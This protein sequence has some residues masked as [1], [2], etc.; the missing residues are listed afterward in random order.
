ME[1]SAHGSAP[2]PPPA[3]GELLNSSLTTHTAK[4]EWKASLWPARATLSRLRMCGAL[5]WVALSLLASPA[6]AA[7]QGVCNRTPQVR[8]KLAEAAGVEHCARVSSGHLAGVRR[9]DL[10]SGFLF[11]L[12]KDDLRGLTG[13]ETLN[14]SGNR[15]WTLPEEVF[16]GLRALRVLRLEHNLI[17]RLPKEVFR[18]LHSLKVL[19]LEDNRMIDFLRVLRWGIFDDVLD[20]LEDLRVDP[21][22]KATI[23]F[24]AT[25]QEAPPGDAVE[26]TA[27]LNHGPSSTLLN[28]GLPVALRIPFSVGGT[29]LAEDFDIPPRPSSGELLFEAGETRQLIYFRLSEAVRAG[30]TIVVRLGEPSAVLTALAPTLPSSWPKACWSGMPKGLFT[31]SPSSTLCWRMSAAGRRRCGMR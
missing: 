20:T 19:R 27:Q 15:L 5:S 1:Y 4:R 21:F 25:A 30:T 16:R 10:S 23:D 2:R 12:R 6:P 17:N 29:A 8:D 26:I 18:G 13:L 7:A 14:L 22:L 11:A 24:T 9:L 31:G 28:S 3:P